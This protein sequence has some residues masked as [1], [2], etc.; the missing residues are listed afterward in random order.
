MSSFST[1]LHSYN[2]SDAVQDFEM[3]QNYPVKVENIMFLHYMFIA[4]CRAANS[5]YINIQSLLENSNVSI[6]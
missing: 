3:A 6:R 1:S 4:P 2:E 5:S